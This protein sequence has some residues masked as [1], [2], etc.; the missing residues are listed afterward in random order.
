MRLKNCLI[1]LA[2][3]CIVF[4]PF[5]SFANGGDQR[6]VDGKYLINLSRAPF[7]PR[8]GKN[9][10]MLISFVDL[11]KNKLVTEDLAVDIHIARLG[12]VGSAKREFVFKKDNMKVVGG[13]LEFP[14]TF[15]QTGLHEVFI[16]FTFASHSEEIY[17]SPDFLLD[18]QGPEAQRIFNQWFFPIVSIGFIGGILFGWF[19]WGRKKLLL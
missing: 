10:S 19:F 11:Q 9:L 4:P 16:D 13:V 18:V 12:G 1:L 14:Y 3:V 17:E 5:F 15:T 8:V 7:T 2:V 6:V